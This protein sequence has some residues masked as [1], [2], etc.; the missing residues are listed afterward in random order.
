MKILLEMGLS[1]VC[2][3][4]W[5]VTLPTVALVKMGATIARHRDRC[6][7]AVGRVITG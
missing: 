5:S 2:L 1:F 3:L 4:F 7:T 6:R